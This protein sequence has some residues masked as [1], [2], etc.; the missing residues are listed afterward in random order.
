MFRCH[1]RDCQHV[2]GG[3]YAAAMYFKRKDVHFIK[4]ALAHYSTPSLRNGLNKRGFCGKCGS[5]ISG[6]ESEEGIGFDAG[7]LDDPAMFRPTLDV[8]VADAQPWDILDPATQKFEG[9]AP[10]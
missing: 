4:G 7:S 1:C 5:R 9:Y 10:M 8:F 3:P 6:D 2:T